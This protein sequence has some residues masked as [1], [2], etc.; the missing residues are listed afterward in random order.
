MR[1]PSPATTG[2]LA[3]LAPLGMEPNKNRNTHLKILVKVQFENGDY[4]TIGDLPPRLLWHHYRFPSGA[5]SALPTITPYRKE[6]GSRTRNMQISIIQIK[7]IYRVL[8]R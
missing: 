8:N 2:D 7:L 1:T 3:R 4:R 6:E 5:S